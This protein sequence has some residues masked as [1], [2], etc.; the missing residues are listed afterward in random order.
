MDIA[1]CWCLT[2]FLLQVLN[3]SVHYI[4]TRGRH[5]PNACSGTTST[6]FSPDRY[7]LLITLH[8]QHE[9]S[10]TDW[11]NSWQQLRFWAQVTIVELKVFFWMSFCE[12]VFLLPLKA[13]KQFHEWKGCFF[14]FLLT[15]MCIN[16]YLRW[17]AAHCHCCRNE[18]V[19][20]SKFVCALVESISRL[21][22]RS[23][24]WKEFSR[25]CLWQ[26]RRS[27]CFI[28]DNDFFFFFFYFV[29]RLFFF[30]YFINPTVFLH[31]TNVTLIF[32][33]N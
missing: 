20:L 6:A 5:T 18:L 25:L 11:K 4:I 2:V 1:W 31:I 3:S 7:S 33:Y 14:F 9:V 13:I 8:T 26:Q 23:S 17:F 29:F 21:G 16:F 15:H 27:V 24:W 28:F 32:N 30:F 12:V 10:A 22:W 19:P